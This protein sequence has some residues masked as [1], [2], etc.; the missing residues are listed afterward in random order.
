MPANK[1]MVSRFADLPRFTLGR[2]ADLPDEPDLSATMYPNFVECVL[3]TGEAVSVSHWVPLYTL[4]R[5]FG[6]AERS[7]GHGGDGSGWCWQSANQRGMVRGPEILLVSSLLAPSHGGAFFF[8]DCL[9]GD[10]FRAEV[11]IKVI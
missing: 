2:R 11:R 5:D 9:A 1:D 10:P 6:Q 3:P 4:D 8:L 7:V